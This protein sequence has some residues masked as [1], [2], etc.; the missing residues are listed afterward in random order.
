VRGLGGA[1]SNIPPGCWNTTGFRDC[2]NVVWAL[3][4]RS[5]AEL[6]SKDPNCA[7]SLYEAGVMGDCPCDPPITPSPTA[8]AAAAATAPD[9]DVDWTKIAIV[10]LLGLGVYFAVR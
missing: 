1:P 3:S 5:C 10:G 7:L 9:D 6:G 4:Q 8:A 2:A